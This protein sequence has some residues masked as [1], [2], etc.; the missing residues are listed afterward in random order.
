MYQALKG[1]G[2]D[3]FS[4]VLSII[5]LVG[6]CEFS[7]WDEDGNPIA[8]D[9]PAAWVQ[10]AAT[11]R[12]QTKNTMSLIPGML[13]KAT[14]AEFRL[15]VQ[16]EIVYAYGGERRLES[17]SASYRTLEGNRVTWATLG[18][19]Q[20]WTPSRGGHDLYDTITDNL[21]KTGG[22]FIAIT[23]AY[24]P[25]EMSVAELIRDEQEKV[26][27]GLS[28]PSGFLYMSREAHPDAPLDIDWVPYILETVRGDATWLPIDVIVKKMQDGARSPSRVRRMYFNQVTATEDAFFSPNDWDAIRAADTYG[29]ERDLARGDEIVLGFDGGKTDDATA[30]VAIRIRDKLIV[31]LLIEQKPDGPM[32]DTWQIQPHLVDEAVRR[33]FSDFTVRAFYADVAL[34]ESYIARWSEDFREV[35]LVKASSN[36]TVGWDMRGHREEIARGTEAFLQTVLDGQIHH[37]GNKHLRSHVLNAKRGH[38][39][40]GLIFRKDNPESPRKID[41]LAAAFVAFMAL[42]KY[43]ESGKKPVTQYRRRMLQA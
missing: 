33:A 37:N 11:S 23:N 38:N 35:L 3:P 21:T 8:K 27:A 2:K 15:D 5:N 24:E 7:H 16:K 40:K 28:T 32:G 31:P 42:N 12:D 4:A 10:V 20:H 6:P 18:E 41:A 17:V 43:L 14:R 26:W 13:P 39:G 1:A 36:S 22:R 30:L 25:G 34:W 9:N 19:T 29:D